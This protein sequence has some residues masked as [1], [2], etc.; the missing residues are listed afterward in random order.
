MRVLP[1]VLAATI[2][3]TAVAAA[4]A[5][6]RAEPGGGSIVG[7][8]FGPGGSI[9]GALA[10]R[11]GRRLSGR[12]RLGGRFDRVGVEL[13]LS[14]HG[15]TGDGDASLVSLMTTPTVAYYLVA[16]PP[17]QVA[18]RV[19]LGYGGIQ[20]IE[21]QRRVP[22][23]PDRP[24]IE[25]WETV[26]VDVPGFVVDAGATVQLHLG[27]GRGQRPVLWADLSVQQARF[28]VDDARVTGRLTQLTI[29]IAHAAEL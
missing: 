9:D 26:P 27:R 24:C 17:L 13:A 3:A 16:R 1:L 18:A 29:G 21:A 4:P 19:G 28:L 6:A 10:D 14:F 11:F 8:G 2:A 5:P 20:G 7:L 25:A 12:L 23:K 15:L 22:C